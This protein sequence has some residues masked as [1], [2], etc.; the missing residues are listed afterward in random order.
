MHLTFKCVRKISSN[1]VPRL[2]PQCDGFLIEVPDS[3]PAV[4]MFKR[5]EVAHG[6]EFRD[7]GAQFFNSS[8]CVGSV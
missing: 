1:T 2:H 8:P 5:E 4:G 6:L 3:V 7:D